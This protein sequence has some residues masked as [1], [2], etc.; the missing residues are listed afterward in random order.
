MVAETF[1]SFVDTLHRELPNNILRDTVLNSVKS[2]LKKTL[3]DQMLHDTC[4]RLAGNLERLL[5][6]K[7]VPVWSR[8]TEFEWIPAEICEVKTLK[9]FNRL[10]NQIVFASLAGSIVPLQLVQFWSQRKTHYLATY[11]DQKGLGF[12]FSRSKI[13]RRGEQVNRML[14]YDVR[15][16][17]GLRCLLLLDPTRSKDD[18]YAFE[19]GHSSSLMKYNRDL[20]FYRD[21]LSNPCVRGLPDSQ[22]CFTCPFGTDKCYLATHPVTYTTG[23]CPRCGAKGFFDPAEQDHVGICVNCVREERKS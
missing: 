17:Y 5:D 20:L 1:H 11:R 2:V 18:P 22:E 4:W 6:Q 12:G 14:F 9:R 21:R 3:T 8:Q 16:F 10:E 23:E 15:Q 7:P 19:I 13:N